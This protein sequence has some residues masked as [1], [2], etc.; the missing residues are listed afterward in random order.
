MVAVAW[1]HILSSMSSRG[2][3][4]TKPMIPTATSPRQTTGK[5]RHAHHPTPITFSETPVD[6]TRP[7]PA[8][9]EHTEEV[10]ETPRKTLATDVN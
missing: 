2:H 3:T 1:A 7:E 8:L 4:A 10:L 6:S 5:R 9:G